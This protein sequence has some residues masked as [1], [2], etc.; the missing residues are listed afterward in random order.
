MTRPQTSVGCWR[1]RC[2]PRSC[3]PCSCSATAWPRIFSPRPPATAPAQDGASR[4]Q[5]LYYTT[6]LA[7]MAALHRNSRHPS[8]TPTR[9]ALAPNQAHA[10]PS[11]RSTHHARAGTRAKPTR[12]PGGDRMS[13]RIEQADALDLLR[14]LPGWVGADLHHST[15]TRRRPRRTLA[16]LAEVTACCAT[17]ARCGFSR[18]TRAAA[19]SRQLR[20]EGWLRSTATPAWAQP[21]TSRCPGGWH[22]RLLLLSHAAPV[23]LST[24]IRSR[25][26]RSHRARSA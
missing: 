11:P 6:R 13:W 2:R 18:P 20:E 23:L 14:E 21:L 5:S 1:S 17:T 8:G 3:G 19:R 22:P 7:R 9:R 24:L 12:D 10:P 16:I 26:P 25:A 15:A 4:L